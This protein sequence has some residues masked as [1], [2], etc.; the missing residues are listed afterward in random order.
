MTQVDQHSLDDDYYLTNFHTLAGFVVD[1]YAD[2]LRPDEIDWYERVNAVSVQAQR[3]YIRLL[4]RKRST[5]R[6]SRVQYAEIEDC[7]QCAEALA[8]KGLASAKPPEQLGLLLPSFTKPELVDRLDLSDYKHLSRADLVEFITASPWRAHYQRELQA[9]DRWVTPQGHSS[10]ML[11]QLCFFG[12]LYQNSSEFVLRQLG[13]LQYETYPFDS[14]S[15]AFM[16]RE[17]IEAHWRYFECEALFDCANPRDAVSLLSLASSLPVWDGADINLRR[18][19]DR[20][21]NRIARQLERL[22]KHD[23]AM[24]LYQLSLHPP[25]RER[26]VRRYLAK[27]HYQAGLSLSAQMLQN[28]HNEAERL[29]ARRLQRECQKGIGLPIKKQRV[30]KPETTILVLRDNGARVESLARQFYSIKGRCFRT[31]NTLVNGV[32]GLFIWDIIFHPVPGV[33]FNPFQMAPADFHHPQFKERRAALLSKRFT[34]LNDVACFGARVIG[35]FEQHAGKLNPLVRWQGLSDELLAL[36][37]E[38]IPLAHWRALFTRILADTRENTAGFPDLVLFPD[39]GGYEFIEIKG[40]GDALQAHQRRWMKYFDQHGIACR[41]VH[42]RYRKSQPLLENAK[43][44]SVSVDG[45]ESE[46]VLMDD[47]AAEHL[48][49]DTT[50]GE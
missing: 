5:F 33:F 22:A 10:W 32:L 19:V 46:H 23:E 49:A 25:A 12:N 41:L 44:G 37:I 30:F 21:R 35:A 29:M 11:M 28:P 15:R 40:P 50:T 18:R 45:A 24:A 42:V 38:R 7:A 36:A 8:S 1:T 13:T 26:R 14:S 2:L 6:L 48:V 34:E 20:L 47:V 9:A 39:S 4:T 17:Q 3:L 31:E 43:T 16:S 27:G